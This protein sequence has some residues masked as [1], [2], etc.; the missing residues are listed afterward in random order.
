MRKGAF[1]NGFEGLVPTRS[2][3]LN[4]KFLAS[5]DAPQNNLLKVFVFK[6]YYTQ[7]E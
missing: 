5:M 2:G 1:Y 3:A 4:F 6:W 7:A